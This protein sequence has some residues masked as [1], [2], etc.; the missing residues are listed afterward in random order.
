MGL[1]WKLQDSSATRPKGPPSVFPKP[2]LSG[3]LWE[4]FLSGS[5]TALCKLLRWLGLVFFFF[6][7]Y[8]ILC[9]DFFFS[10][11]HKQLEFFDTGRKTLPSVVPVNTNPGGCLSKNPCPKPV[12]SSFWEEFFWLVLEG[13]CSVSSPGCS[14][15]RFPS[16]FGISSLL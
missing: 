11:K 4:G 15:W 3:F 9:R 2:L 6:F 13:S 12:F 14:V 10:I 5:Q 1:F 8:F 16:L 7:F